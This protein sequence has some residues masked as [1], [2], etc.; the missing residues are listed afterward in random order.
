MRCPIC[1]SQ[2]SKVTNCRVKDAK[3]YR[4]RTCLDC[5]EKFTT[6]EVDSGMLMAIFE[7]QFEGSALARIAE[8]LESEF[9]TRSYLRG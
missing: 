9:P 7:D 8:I 2:N 5:G 6:Y 1:D 3:F 4:R